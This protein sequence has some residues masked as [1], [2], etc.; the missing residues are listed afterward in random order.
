M[1]NLFVPL[2]IRP[3]L[4]H[5]FVNQDAVREFEKNEIMPF[6][7]LLSKDVFTYL[8]RQ[9]FIRK[10]LETSNKVI[11]SPF[12]ML[13]E[14][15]EGYEKLTKRYSEVFGEEVILHITMSE[16]TAVLLDKEFWGRTV[17]NY[18][19]II[20]D[21]WEPTF[22]HISDTLSMKNVFDSLKYH[23]NDSVPFF[24]QFVKPNASYRMNK[25]L[26]VNNISAAYHCFDFFIFDTFAQSGIISENSRYEK[27]N[28]VDV[29]KYWK[30]IKNNTKTKD[31]VCLNRSFKPHRPYV[32]NELYKRGLLE[33]SYYSLAEAPLEEHQ[34][35]E[36]IQD[37][38]MPILCEDEPE[39]NIVDG[40]MHH[41]SVGN[42]DWIK[43]SKLWITTESFMEHTYNDSLGEKYT[44]YEILFVSE[45][46][47]KAFAWGMPFVVFGAPRI[48]QYVKS[49]GF[50]TFD[51]FIDQT[52]DTDLDYK[53]RFDHVLKSI[54]TFVNNEW[55]DKIQDE[56]KF[57]LD[58]FYDEKLYLKLA[59]NMLDNI[60]NYYINKRVEVDWEFRESRK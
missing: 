52:Y 51:D 19:M 18:N 28:I 35:L 8:S 41:D 25:W 6:C 23:Y 56:I 58:L 1:I 49:L 47:Y 37:K 2:D 13:L 20:T 9:R 11:I 17:H 55:P 42:I 14:D 54:E 53:T 39:H 15:I 50:K 46:V 48:L 34:E 27:N 21:A 44:P 22:L 10:G 32:V 36:I 59:S 24:T 60:V 26:N 43:N 38:S 45:K 33:N 30:E 57:N 40:N 3:N 12:V 7:D 29:K 31:V 5:V 16:Y 4:D